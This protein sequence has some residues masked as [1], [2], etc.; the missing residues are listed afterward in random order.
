[1]QNYAKLCDILQEILLIKLNLYPEYSF[2]IMIR[3]LTFYE[4]NI[5]GVCLSKTRHHRNARELLYLCG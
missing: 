5:F 2:N 1:M 4:E 3:I